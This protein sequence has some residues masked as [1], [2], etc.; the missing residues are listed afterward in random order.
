MKNHFNNKIEYYNLGVTNN[1]NNYFLNI[2]VTKLKTLAEKLRRNI[3]VCNKK[4]SQSFFSYTLTKSLNTFTRNFI[5]RVLSIS[6]L[7]Y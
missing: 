1:F 6:Q 4:H 5:F 3:N 2:C 7:M